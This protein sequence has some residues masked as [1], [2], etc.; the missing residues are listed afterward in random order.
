MKEDYCYEHLTSFT[1]SDIRQQL[2]AETRAPLPAQT[3][4]EIL[5]DSTPRFV[6]ASD[7][8]NSVGLLCDCNG[9]TPNQAG[10]GDTCHGA[11]AAAFSFR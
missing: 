9:N 11:G 2:F 1:D 7:S 6:P 3:R 4:N 10:E 5:D 8:F